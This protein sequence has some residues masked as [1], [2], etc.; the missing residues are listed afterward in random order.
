MVQTTIPHAPPNAQ[1]ISSVF[2]EVFAF[3][4]H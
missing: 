2:S 1:A 4:E 3:L